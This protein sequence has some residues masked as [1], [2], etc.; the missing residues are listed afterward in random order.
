MRG[1]ASR[2]PLARVVGLVGLLALLFS[3]PA[4]AQ[5]ASELQVVVVDDDA[6]PVHGATV[7]SGGVEVE[8][9]V[10][11]RATI[12]GDGGAPIAVTHPSLPDATIEWP[13]DGGG[14]TIPLERPVLR[15]VH[16]G[17]TLVG[18]D[19]WDELVELTNETSLN[20]FML[21]IKDESGRIYPYTNVELAI[22]AGAALNRWDLA[23]VTAELQAEGIAVIGRIVT[24]QDP[25]AGAAFPDIAV[26]T[27]SG[28]PFSRAGL[29]FLDPTDPTARE[30]GL[31]LAEEACAAGIDEL[32][33]DY[34]RYP[35]GSH[36]GLVFDNGNDDATRIETIR[37]FLIEARRR[38]VDGCDIAADVF[39][40]TTSIDGDGGLGQDF[41]VLSEVL[42][43]ISPMSY[44]NH[45]GQGW[46]GFDSPED[47]PGGVIAGSMSDALAREPAATVRPW[48]QDFGG[49]GPEEVRAQ[50]DAADRLGL[51]WM[52]WN[53]FSNYTEAGIPSNDE[54]ITPMSVGDPASWSPIPGGFWDGP[55]ALVADPRTFSGANTVV[56]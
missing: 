16:V 12:T 1:Q 5:P 17:G 45:W 25:V 28:T 47:N 27:P 15:A 54:I 3:A 11:G 24:F 32:Q 50:I 19:R 13:T 36:N 43:V 20:A 6:L 35:D 7:T 8:T 2:V 22:D 33:F 14:I 52:L 29:T 4:S 10:F 44:P 30:Y 39:G 26:Q 48:L 37:S 40:F 23:E 31:Q 41:D 56:G 34:V 55:F 46:F 51:G 9:N 53:V 49:Y 38:V 18:T 42:D 21:D